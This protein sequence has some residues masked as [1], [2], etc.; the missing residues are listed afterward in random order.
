M[1]EP[2]VRIIVLYYLIIIFFDIQ[3]H[4]NQSMYF[5][6]IPLFHRYYIVRLV[7]FT[8]ILI[9]EEPLLP[10]IR[11]YRMCQP[12]PMGSLYS[13]QFRYLTEFQYIALNR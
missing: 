9:P 13:Q 12:W 10:S 7:H 1:I 6:M 3:K 11:Y 8:Q 2:T 5:L 4:S